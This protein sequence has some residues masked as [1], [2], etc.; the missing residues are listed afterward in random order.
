MERKVQELGSQ[1]NADTM[2]YLQSNLLKMRDKIN[3]FCD[4]LELANEAEKKA[5][6]ITAADIQRLFEELN[7][8]REM[9]LR[10]T[11]KNMQ[12]FN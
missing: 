8:S 10:E 4:R 9:N 1:L 3:E 7:E 6:T 12:G 11:L 2:M 5:V